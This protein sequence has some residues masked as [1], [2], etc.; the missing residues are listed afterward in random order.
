M[1]E[2]RG[3]KPKNTAVIVRFSRTLSLGFDGLCYHLVST[4]KDTN[5]IKSTTNNEHTTTFYYSGFSNAIYSILIENDPKTIEKDRR[6]H[7]KV[8]E[9]NFKK[10]VKIKELLS[11][12]RKATRDD[13][14][15]IMK[16]VPANKGY[17][18]IDYIH[19][20]SKEK[21][22][23]EGLYMNE[24]ALEKY[25]FEANIKMKR[26]EDL[27]DVKKYLETTWK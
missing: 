12:R 4:L 13:L 5:H 22:K 19:P 27:N 21:V 6:D 2:K 24:R 20:V 23:S 15:R 7:F 10:L 25:I 1:T 11:N 16:V 26:F 18:D 3:R 17:F 8:T 14:P 9:S